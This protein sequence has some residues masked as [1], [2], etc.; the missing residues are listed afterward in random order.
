MVLCGRVVLGVLCN[1]GK[2]P[3]TYLYPLLFHLFQISL[4]LRESGGAEFP[5]TFPIL[6][7]PAGID[8]NNIAGES[9]LAHSF[10]HSSSFI[11]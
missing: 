4:R 2:L 6:F 7:K 3:Q 10:H 11:S 5:L 9:T 1:T 8:M